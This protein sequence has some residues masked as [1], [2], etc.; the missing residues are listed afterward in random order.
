M[1]AEH[2]TRTYAI[3]WL[4]NLLLV[5]C[6]PFSTMLVG[7][8]AD[9]PLAIWVYVG[10]LGLNGLTALAM[11]MS[12][13]EAHEASSERRGGVVVLIVSC[14]LAAL[15]ALFA[16]RLALWALLLNALPILA[17]RKRSRPSG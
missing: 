3:F 10:N 11:V 8:Y 9:V 4:A 5:T 15:I 16:P 12:M 6:V 1:A 14:T 7:R 13:R 2:V 17:Y